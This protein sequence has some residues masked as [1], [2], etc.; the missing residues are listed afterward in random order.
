MDLPYENLLS[1]KIK[2]QKCLLFSLAALYNPKHF[3]VFPKQE[4]NGEKIDLMCCVLW[5][6]HLDMLEYE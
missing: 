2:S 1:A 4:W 3:G 5:I 6:K